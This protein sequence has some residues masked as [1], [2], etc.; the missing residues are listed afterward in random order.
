MKI[1]LPARRQEEVQELL[2]T[3]VGDKIN[4]AILTYTMAKGRTHLGE[5]ER[6]LTKRGVAS[7]RS[8]HKR[9]VLL[10]NMGI[11]KSTV[12]QIEMKGESKPITAWVRQ[13]QVSG[14]HED[15]IRKLLGPTKEL[16]T[17]PMMA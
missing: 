1:E 4:K 5:M 7:R 9:L 8:I 15:W 11:L 6:E 10:N 3:V 12:I 13:Y 14:V 2:Q 16:R 17:A